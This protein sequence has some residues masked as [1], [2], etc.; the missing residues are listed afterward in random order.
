[1]T[2]VELKCK[3]L[4]ANPDS[5]FFDR[6]TMNFFGDTMHNYGVLSYDEKTWMLYRK[7]PVKY[8]LQSPA[9]FDKETFKRVFPDY[10][11]GGQQ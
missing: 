6:E 5:K 4:Q 1:M 2:P 11:Q 10:R 3:V 8:G 9:F 7:R